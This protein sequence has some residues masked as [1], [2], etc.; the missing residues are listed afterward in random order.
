MANEFFC[1]DC[2]FKSKQNAARSLV[3]ERKFK[4][5]L[6]IRKIIFVRN[7][8]MQIYSNYDVIIQI[9]L[10]TTMAEA[11]TSSTIARFVMGFTKS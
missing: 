1:Q 9:R 6:N 10:A 7:L 11:L 3:K 8:F 5:N 2:N 4:S